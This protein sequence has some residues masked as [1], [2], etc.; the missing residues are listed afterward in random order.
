MCGIAFIRLRKDLSYFSEKYKTPLYALNKLHLLMEKQRNRGHDG[1]GVAFLKLNVPPGTKY[2]SRLRSLAADPITDIFNHINESFNEL[3]K[4]H[5]EK[6]QNEEWLKKI[7]PYYSEILLGH[8]R[9]G[10]HGGLGIDYC[11]PMVRQNNW[12]SKNLII[13]GNFNL[14]NNDELFDKL[15]EIGQHPRDTSDMNTILEK[16]GHFIDEENE[17]IYQQSKN[18]YSKK[19][20]SGIIEEKLNLQSVLQNAFKYFDGGYTIAGIAGHGAS[21]IARDPWGIRPA[22]YYVNDELVVSASE[23]SA[24]QTVF[25]VE[26]SEINEIKPG[27]ALIIDKYGN[28]EEKL[29]S[30]PLEKKSCSFERIYFS[31]G[32]DPDIYKERKKL[33][34]LLIPDV[35]KSIEYNLKDTI[36]G[37]IP[38]TAETAFL[39]MMRELENYIK[40]FRMKKFLENKPLSET[41]LDELLDLRPRIG[42]IIIKDVKLRTFITNDSQRGD[43]V[44]HVY[45]TTYGIVRKNI[46]TLV[47]I[48]DSIVRGTTLENSI[49]KMLDRLEPK[50]IIIVSSAPQIRYPDCYGIDMSRL[51]DFIAFRATVHLLEE[52]DM[53]F[54]LDEVYHKCKENENCKSGECV[55]YVKQIYEPFTYNEITNE[56][57][58]MIRFKGMKA[59]VEVVYQSVENLH[60]ACPNHSGDWYFTG[61]YATP[62]G[63][64]VANRAFMNYMEGSLE[65]AY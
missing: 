11:H 62:G 61:D 27:Y 22:F 29:V 54:L 36:F 16:V 32:N 5:K 58:R 1:A 64:R 42:K 65:R 10:T 38:N 48:D 30:E 20:I 2:T 12:K 37:Y 13:A 57:A 59:E 49:L 52:R 63:N 23:R 17:D 21:F 25:N 39:G 45:D 9:Y 7:S 44:A 15:L 18:N 31:R 50:K 41:Q 28:H 60:I 47:V 46:D 51:K 26:S 4:E 33:G 6:V 43:L 19:E 8:L 34:E 3:K 35:L 55:N 24:I 40:K 14:T 56:I 53:T